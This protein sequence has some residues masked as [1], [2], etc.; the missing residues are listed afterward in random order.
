MRNVCHI[1]TT[2]SSV[3]ARQHGLHKPHSRT[4]HTVNNRVEPTNTHG[5]AMSLPGGR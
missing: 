4:D 2:A 5:M 1:L 3:R